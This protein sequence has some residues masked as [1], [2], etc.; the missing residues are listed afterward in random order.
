[1]SANTRDPSLASILVARFLRTNNYTQTLRAFI[2]EAG[3]PADAGHVGLKKDN[4]SSSWTIEGVIEEK[5]VFD[6][7]IKSERYG[8]AGKDND[9]WS[10]PGESSYS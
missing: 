7:S 6:Q 8:D 4:D 9:L 3:L 5:R 2:Q 1:M 10:S